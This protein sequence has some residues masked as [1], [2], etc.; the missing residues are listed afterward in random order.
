MLIIINT[1]WCPGCNVNI[2]SSELDDSICSLNKSLTFSAAELVLL[3]AGGGKVLMVAQGA[4]SWKKV[5][6][7]KVD[8]CGSAAFF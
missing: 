4:N 6:C 1:M 2:S 3:T 7:S 5:W 8:C